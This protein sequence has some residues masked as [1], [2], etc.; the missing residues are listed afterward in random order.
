MRADTV[1]KIVLVAVAVVLIAAT[2][3]ALAACNPA[4]TVQAPDGGGNT[5]PSAPENPD[6]P[7]TPEIPD[8]PETPEIPDTPENPDT[9]DTPDTP[10]NPET[11]ELTEAEYY[12]KNMELLKAAIVEQYGKDFGDFAEA[13][14]KINE[15][16]KF[17]VNK[18]AGEIY[19]FG[20]RFDIFGGSNNLFFVAKFDQNILAN[21]QKNISSILTE[22][23]HNFDISFQ[24][25]KS[26]R[27]NLSEEVY[28]E[29]AEY[30]LRQSYSYDEG[31]LTFS[32]GATLLDI[33]QYIDGDAYGGQYIQ[34]LVVDGD[35]ICTARLENAMPSSMYDAGIKNLMTY[36]NNVFKVTEVKPFALFGVD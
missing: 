17:L 5:P 18:A 23:P 6:T 21:T 20:D 33:S 27:S 14:L 15:D 34:F 9:P 12:E 13:S 31:T 29:F 2:L 1:S 26:I 30:L 35:R 24:F 8:T 25:K 19:F 4:S 3:L 28:N 22:W 36:K 32:D 11:P 16:Q 10:E 7:E